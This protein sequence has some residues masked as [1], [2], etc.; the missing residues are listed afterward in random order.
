MLG[1]THEEAV[2]LSERHVGYDASGSLGSKGRVGVN[3]R[4]GE[5]KER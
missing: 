1:L 2:Q 4:K 3:A 5:V